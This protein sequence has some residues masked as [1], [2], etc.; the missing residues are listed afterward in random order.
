M[1]REFYG[2]SWTQWIV[3]LVCYGVFFFFG[4]IEASQSIYYSLIKTELEIPYKI[5]GWLVSM[6]SYSFIIGSPI[7]GYI[8]TQIIF[9]HTCCCTISR[10]FG[11]FLSLYS[12]RDWE[13]LCWML[14]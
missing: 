12:L 8:M 10:I 4:G 2:Y 7:V 3:I 11:L 14:V 6:G 1:Q 5:Q 13:V 9:S